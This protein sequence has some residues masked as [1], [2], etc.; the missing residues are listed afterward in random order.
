MGQLI[1]T[2]QRALQEA[3][4][5]QPRAQKYL[6]FRLAEDTYGLEVIRVK[7]II[8]YS[9]LVHVPMVPPF[10]KGILNLLGQ[11]VPVI[12]LSVCFGIEAEEVTRQ[13]CI[14][15]VEVQ[16]GD[17]CVDMGVIV[18]AVHNVIELKQENI[19]PAPDFGDHV[20]AHFIHGIG[21]LDEQFIMLLDMSYVLSAEDLGH[22][23]RLR[24]EEL[25]RQRQAPESQAKAETA[26]HED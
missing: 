16:R 12:D 20:R 22:I 26:E 10:I 3:Q 1:R 7:K 2:R 18:D 14:V 6:T 19:A 23:A 15:I 24:E 8:E 5:R 21:K 13:T 17:A 25:K 4:T 11:V 9:G